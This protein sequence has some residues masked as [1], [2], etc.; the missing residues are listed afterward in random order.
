MA[1]RVT[2]TDRVFASLRESI[3]GGEFPAGS[4]HSIYRLADLLGVSR[5]PVREAVLRLADSGLVTIE[6][7]R[8]VRIRGV[9]VGDIKAVFELRLMIEVPS[10]AYAAEHAGE[11]ELDT[12]RA[13][14]DSMRA[15]AE[16]LDEVR[17]TAHDRA[18]HHAIGAILGNAKALQEVAALRD[19]IQTRGASTLHRSRGMAEILG[20]HVPIVEAVVARDPGAAAAHMEEHLVSTAALLMDQAAS[21]EDPAPG[22]DWADHLRRHLYAPGRTAAR[23]E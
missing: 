22:P 15:A 18:L 4:L 14:L 10:A 11:A 6:R 23:R 1:A 17:F 7:N 3:L 12:L 5:T 20:E 9:S 19:S 21:S 13:E 8:G 2:T 16:G